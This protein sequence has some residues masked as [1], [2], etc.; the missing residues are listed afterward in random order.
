MAKS[1]RASRNSKDINSEHELFSRY[2]YIFNIWTD[3]EMPYKNVLVI[4]YV[5]SVRFLYLFC[6]YNTNIILS[7]ESRGG[8]KTRLMG[9][10][11]GN[12]VKIILQIKLI[13]TKK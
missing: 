9:G 2:L 4:Y 12:C 3:N 13:G 5:L 7:Y 6:N 11:N 1:R 8:S 10:E